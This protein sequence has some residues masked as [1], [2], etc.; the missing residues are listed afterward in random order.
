MEK[1]E[2]LEKKGKILEVLHLLHEVQLELRHCEKR[3][4]L[5]M[6]AILDIHEKLLDIRGDYFRKDHE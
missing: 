6:N 2:E 4:M 5:A 1:E 3:V